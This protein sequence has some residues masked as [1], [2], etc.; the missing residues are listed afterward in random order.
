MAMTVLHRCGTPCPQRH[1]IDRTSPHCA[2]QAQLGNRRAGQPIAQCP[3]ADFH[4]SEAHERAVGTATCWQHCLFSG[5]AV[6][7][8][9]PA[10]KRTR[11]KAAQ[12]STLRR[13]PPEP[14]AGVRSS[15]PPPPPVSAHSIHGGVSVGSGAASPSQTQARRC[16]SD[17]SRSTT[18][19]ARHVT[20]HETTAVELW[21]TTTRASQ[22][23]RT[24]WHSDSN[25]AHRAVRHLSA[26]TSL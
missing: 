22:W 20:S 7:Q 17:A 18:R 12:E 15:S 4:A 21:T 13:T 24:N 16:G 8:T 26:C 2:C 9:Q 14:P 19:A 10:A 3:Q 5:S 23:S 1:D 25:G 11:G 6:L